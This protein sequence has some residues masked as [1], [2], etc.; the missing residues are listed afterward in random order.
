MFIFGCTVDR[1]RNPVMACR[2]WQN[3]KKIVHQDSDY[4]TERWMNQL[5]KKGF[6]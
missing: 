5:L 1:R 2:A 4:T 3:D 6:E